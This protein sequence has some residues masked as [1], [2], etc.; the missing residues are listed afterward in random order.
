VLPEDKAL[1]PDLRLARSDLGVRK[2]KEV[3]WWFA[4]LVGGHVPP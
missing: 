3:S 2:V 4:G 1:R